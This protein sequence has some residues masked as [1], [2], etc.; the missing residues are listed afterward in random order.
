MQEVAAVGLEVL[1]ALEPLMV[2]QK[3]LPLLMLRAAG[4]VALEVE[5]LV[6]EGLL[7]LEVLI[8]VLGPLLTNSSSLELS[9][10]HTPTH[11]R[12]AFL[13]AKVETERGREY[14]LVEKSKSP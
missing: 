12:M 7:G 4:V 1:L 5:A 9:V 6:V 3:A 13:A 2:V 8:L 14:P 11:T 10:T